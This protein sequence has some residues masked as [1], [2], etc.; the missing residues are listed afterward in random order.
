MATTS[1]RNQTRPSEGQLKQLMLDGMLGGRRACSAL[2]H[3][4]TPL[5]TAFYGRRLR[6]G[7]ADVEDLVQETLI[8]MHV[9]RSSFDQN[10]PFTPWLFAIARHKLIDYFRA[11]RSYQPIDELGEIL[12]VEGFEDSSNARLDT[13]RLLRA[14]PPKQ[15]RAIRQTRLKGLSVAEAAAAAG[16]GISDVKIS[17]HRGLKT[18][19]MQVAMSAA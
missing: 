13:D 11:R 8:A 9:R 17:V 18:L 14:L 10:R 1:S 19:A 5:L 6:D 12:R 16:I 7:A 4:V 2:L 15:A 3:A